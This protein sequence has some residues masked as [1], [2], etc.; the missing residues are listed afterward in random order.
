MTLLV[1]KLHAHIILAAVLLLL[2][3]LVYGLRKCRGNRGTALLQVAQTLLWLL[4]VLLCEGVKK[5]LLIVGFWQWIKYISFCQTV[6]IIFVLFKAISSAINIVADRQIK[7]G[8]N[9][10]KTLVVIRA[11]NI[12]TLFLLATLFGEQLGLN[13][14]GLLTFG[15]GS[16]A[17]PSVSPAAISWAT[18]SPA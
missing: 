3:G 15:G 1:E 17:W 2:S 6:L 10:S 7:N 4:L 16:V 9:R 14:S 13:M 18:C 12:I 8:I 5:Y 11:I